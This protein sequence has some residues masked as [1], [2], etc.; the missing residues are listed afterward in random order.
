M[1]E[2]SPDVQLAIVGNTIVEVYYD[3]VLQPKVE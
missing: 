1:N 3:V 2:S